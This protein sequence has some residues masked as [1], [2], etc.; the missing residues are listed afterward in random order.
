MRPVTPTLALRGLLL[1]A[2]ALSI[3]ACGSDTRSS[4]PEIV[5]SDPNTEGGEVS[6][7]EAPALVISDDTC[8]TDVDCA[9]AGCCHAAACGA[10]ANA[11]SCEDVACTADCQFGTLDCGGACLCHEGHCAARLSRPPELT[12]R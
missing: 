1:C 2:A 5:L 9:P 12:V 6:E 8:E 11:P 10:V 7:P 3:L 4:E